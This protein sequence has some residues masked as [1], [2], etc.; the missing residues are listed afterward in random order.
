MARPTWPSITDDD[1]TGFTGTIFNLAFFNS[2]KDYIQN[3]LELKNATELTIATGAITITEGFH[4]VD[5]EGDAASDD[6][7]TINGATTGAILVIKPAN[8][9]RTV[10][11]KHNTGNIW[12]KGKADVSLDDLEDALLLFYTGTKW[13]DLSA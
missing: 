5:T 2:I 9:L 11:V 6:L 4:I 8:D 13:T 10:V 7:D 3:G 12:L 1:G